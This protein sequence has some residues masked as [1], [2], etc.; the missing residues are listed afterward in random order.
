MSKRSKIIQPTLAAFGFTKKVVHRGETVDVDLPRY[1][2]ELE[3]GKFMCPKCPKRFK[4]TQGLSVHVKCVH[5]DSSDVQ[6]N[7]VSFS[8]AS[9]R[10]EY[11]STDEKIAEDFAHVMDSLV[12][13]VVGIHAKHV[14]AKEQA[15]KKHHAYTAKIL[16]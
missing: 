1:A 4:N 14:S 9:G 6:S 11:Q 10:T 13:K 16:S 8:K 3:C 12:Q 15:G 5:G 7:R 2:N